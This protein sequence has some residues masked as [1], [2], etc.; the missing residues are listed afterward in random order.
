MIYLFFAITLAAL[1]ILIWILAL[2]YQLLNDESTATK[3]PYSYSK[4]QL[5]WWTFIVISCII[6]LF[7]IT[8][9]I[10]KLDTTTLALLGMGALTSG[11]ARAIDVSD[12]KATAAPAP[13]AA[14]PAA[15]AVPLPPAAPVPPIP[16]LS[17]NQES[18]GFLLDILSDNTGISIARLQSLLFNLV[19]GLYYLYTFGTAIAHLYRHAQ[20]DTILPPFSTEQLALIGLSSVAYLG[21]KTTEN[22]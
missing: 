20:V 19:F 1:L 22:K 2:K 8:G 10:P 5:A 21:L 9:N 7:W 6:T 15:P 4:T 13:P 3:K 12:S 14:A 18:Q 16:V 17:R 11:F